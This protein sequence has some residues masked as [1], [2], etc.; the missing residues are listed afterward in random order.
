MAPD[1]SLDERRELFFLSHQSRQALGTLYQY[2]WSI[3]FPSGGRCR[4]GS[5]RVLCNNSINKRQNAS[6][7]G[8]TKI[9]TIRPWTAPAATAPERKV[10]GEF[11]ALPPLNSVAQVLPHVVPSFSPAPQSGLKMKG[12]LTSSSDM[13]LVPKGLVQQGT[14]LYSTSIFR[15]KGS[16]Q[17]VACC[18]TFST[19]GPFESD[20]EAG[21]FEITP[22]CKRGTKRRI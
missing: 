5:P 16:F 9:C 12:R 7:L 22:L 11:S 6:R 14:V 19:Q 8:I 17:G 3:R 15:P 1:V 13:L 20:C 10:L 4:G 18:Q 2:L 21:G